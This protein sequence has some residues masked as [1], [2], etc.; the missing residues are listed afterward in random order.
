MT[1]ALHLLQSSDFSPYV[2]KDFTIRFS[3]TLAAEAKLLEVIDL[4][5]HPN[6]QRKPFS[7]LFETRQKNQHY[8]Q[9]IYTVEHPDLGALAI[10]L[11]P[12]GFGSEGS[13]YEAVFS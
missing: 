10:F 9:A 3:E 12:V 7:L 13:Q 11:V 2:G 1:S 6:Q 5:A 4:T 8:P